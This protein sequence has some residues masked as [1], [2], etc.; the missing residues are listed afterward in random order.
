MAKRG[1]KPSG[2]DGKPV[3][4][5]FE[6]KL[7]NYERSLVEAAADSMALQGESTLGTSTFWRA[8]IV[9]KAKQILGVTNEP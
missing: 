2:H 7:S 9:D 1:R 3:T 8:V 5:R 6:I 4:S